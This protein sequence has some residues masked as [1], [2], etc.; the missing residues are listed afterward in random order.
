MWQV[1]HFFDPSPSAFA[2]QTLCTSHLASHSMNFLDSYFH[3]SRTYSFSLRVYMYLDASSAPQWYQ[4]CLLAFN[5]TCFSFISH[6][7]TVNINII[8]KQV[9]IHLHDE[10]CSPNQELIDCFSFWY[11]VP[12]KPL[13][14]DKLKYW[15]EIS[16]INCQII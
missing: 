4:F 6:Y 1:S 11:T 3:N 16:S 12:T 15:S 14:I 7:F 13:N 2:I 8:C 10:S 9:T 5:L